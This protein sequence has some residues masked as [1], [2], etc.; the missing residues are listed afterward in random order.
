MLTPYQVWYG[1]ALVFLTGACAGHNDPSAAPALR[2]RELTVEVRN[3]NFYDATIYAWDSGERLRLGMA[4]GKST[5]TFTFRW[6]LGDVRFVI[7]FIGAGELLGERLAVDAGD[8]L[9]LIVGSEDHRRAK[10]PGD[11]VID[12]EARIL[13]GRILDVGTLQP[14]PEVKVT[15]LDSGAETRTSRWGVYRL[16]SDTATEVN[17]RLVLPGYATAVERVALT[18][19]RTIADF[20]LSP[21]DAVLETLLVTETGREIIPGEGGIALRTLNLEEVAGINAGEVLKDIPGV[22]ILQPSGQVGAGAKVQ[23]RGLRSLFAGNEPL[24]YVDGVRTTSFSSPLPWVRGESALDFIPPSQID[25]IE[26]FKGPA[27][28]ARFGTGAMPGVI[29]IYTKKGHVPKPQ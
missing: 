12:Q 6:D 11:D 22:L 21:V 17:V 23:L 28:T 25:R 2:Q 26:V 14:L 10:R 15:F 18:G 9:V 16:V 7:D 20:K 3:Y 4:Q 1:I 5:T 27:A 19:N 13:E 24:V 8:D 29:L